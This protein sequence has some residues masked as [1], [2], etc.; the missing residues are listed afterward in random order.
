[1]ILE[2]IITTRNYNTWPSWDLVYEWENMISNKLGLPFYYEK[3]VMNNRYLKRIPFLLQLFQTPQTAFRFDMVPNL[4]TLVNNRVNIIPCIVDFFLRGKQLKNFYRCYNKNKIVFVS[5]REVYDYLKSVNCPLNIQHLALSI[6]DKYKIDATT[7][8]EKK[9]DLVLMG[10]QNPVLRKFVDE[11][12]A[13]HED[14]RYVYRVQK[15]GAF[16]Y[17]T[18]NGVCLG[19]INSREKYIKLMR[20][21]RVGLYSTPGIDGGEVRTNGFSQVTPRFLELIACGCHVLARYRNNSDTKYY[22]LEKFSPIL[23]TYD[24]FEDAMDKRLRTEVCMKDYSEYLSKHY[25][26]VRC[27]ELKNYIMDL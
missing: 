18:S 25:T 20:S 16:N 21:A 26:S 4:H 3:E 24:E 7:R 22:E 15:D 2:S 10:R 11:Y 8:F 5:S 19:D 6:S 1:M 17:Y 9:Y 27:Q 23:S 14:F 12:A 13:K